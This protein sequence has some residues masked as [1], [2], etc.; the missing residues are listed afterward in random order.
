MRNLSTQAKY[1]YDNRNLDI[2]F[3]AQDAFLH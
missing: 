1:A 3:N 2:Y